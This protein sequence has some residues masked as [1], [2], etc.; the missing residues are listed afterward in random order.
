MSGFGDTEPED[1]WHPEDSTAVLIDN[2]RRRLDLLDLAVL[3]P[4]D[5]IEGRLSVH[6]RRRPSM[7]DRD[8][9]RVDQI[10]EDLGYLRNR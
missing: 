6:L 7:N 4:F 3:D 5:V 9:L 8:R 2:L 10:R 1:A